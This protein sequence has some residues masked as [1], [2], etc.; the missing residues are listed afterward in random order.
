MRRR[1]QRVYFAAEYAILARVSRRR[2][3]GVFRMLFRMPVFLYR[4]G[5]GRLVGRGILLLATTGRRTGKRRLTALGYGFQPET[6]A[7]SVAAG[8]TGGADWFRNAAADPRVQ[9]WLGSGWVDCIAM[10]VPEETAS[11]QY[12]E[13]A[14][15]NPYAGRIFSRWLGR[16]FQGTDEDFLAVGRLFSILSLRPVNID[17]EAE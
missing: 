7:Y 10:P 8:W 15:K 1:L 2:P 6:G 4:I 14:E 5:C 9:I 16:P 13:M 11:R 3:G 17:P 12:R